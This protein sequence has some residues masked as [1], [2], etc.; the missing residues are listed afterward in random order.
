ML[1]A[2]FLGPSSQRLQD[3]TLNLRS[4]TSLRSVGELRRFN[5]D[6]DYLFSGFHASQ[7]ISLRRSSAVEFI[8]MLCGRPDVTQDEVEQDFT[9]QDPSSAAASTEFLRKLKASDGIVRVYD[10]F[11]ETSAGDTNDLVLDVALM[12]FVG[13]LV[14]IPAMADPLLRERA[15]QLIECLM[16]LL[17]R[18]CHPEDQ[19]RQDGLSLLRKTE[20][21]FPKALTRGDRSPLRELRSIAALSGLFLSGSVLPS[22]RN[23]IIANLCAIASLPR[24]IGAQAI[25]RTFNR[26]HEPDQ[27][28]SLID[29]CLQV[30]STCGSNATQRLERFARGLDLSSLKPIESWP[31]LDSVDLCIRLLNQCMETL[32]IDLESAVPLTPEAKDSVIAL[33]RFSMQAAP[34]DSTNSAVER[35]REERM[36]SDR[37]LEL[38]YG[39]TKWLLDL[40][41]VDA[42]WS[43][44]LATSAPF[45]QT[46][47][48][49]MFLAECS[50]GPEARALNCK[51]KA[52]TSKAPLK[53][54]EEPTETSQKDAVS[55]LDDI[56]HLSLAVLTNLLIKQGDETRVT[57]LD[58]RLQPACWRNRSC[59]Y[60]CE[61]DGQISALTSLVR[62]F[63]HK[64]Q[65]A[66]QKEDAND[67]YLASSLATAIAQ[68]AIGGE[69]FLRSVQLEANSGTVTQQTD[70]KGQAETDLFSE[71]VDAVEEFADLHVV[72]LRSQS[73][74]DSDVT[75]SQI[76]MAP[77]L[78]LDTRLAGAEESGAIIRD[79]AVELRRL[80]GKSRQSI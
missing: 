43:R 20:L 22:L 26:E 12:V 70:T 78:G 6:L 35:T 80:I 13:K 55:F 7:P 62:L 64:K 29:I 11:R 14:K 67:A 71:I 52:P 47:L 46:L 25:T 39:L 23:L 48:Q 3:P 4:I 77:N 21:G 49:V 16:R 60:S 31:D 66:S 18:L 19:H 69:T 33:F 37:S 61:C 53:E 73:Q 38:L 58:L 8:R 44:S 54:E 30:F 59:A 75:G 57:L 1:T 15:P 10:L 74:L 2:L 24:R 5:D 63:A 27:S 40:T 9:A 68:F 28:P 36:V 65:T 34:F 76:V 17:L 32:Y 42:S 45:L 41:Q 79:V 50:A 56:V 51:S 72:A